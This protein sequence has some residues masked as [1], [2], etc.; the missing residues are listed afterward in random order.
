MGHE[1]GQKKQRG[2]HCPWQAM[3]IS[4]QMVNIEKGPS[5]GEG[6]WRVFIIDY[7]I[8]LSN[9]CYLFISFRDSIKYL[10]KTQ[11]LRSKAQS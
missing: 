9:M 3:G 2:Q 6:D 11:V 8:Y 7:S 1:Q 5:C 4:V 10:E